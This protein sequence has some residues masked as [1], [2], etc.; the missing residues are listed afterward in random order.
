VYARVAL[1]NRHMDAEL[2]CVHSGTG[3]A[4]GLG[5]LSAGGCLLPVGLAFA[6]R[7][8]AGGGDGQSRSGVVVLE[9][10]GAAGLAFETAVGR[11][12]RVWVNSESV[13]TVLVVGRVLRE[14]D[15]KGLDVAAQKRLV[16]RVLRELS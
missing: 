3:R 16:K 8:L 14:T 12:G 7:L 4:D 10:L 9:E 2:E 11:N 5:P 13:K 6:R 15:E 1:A